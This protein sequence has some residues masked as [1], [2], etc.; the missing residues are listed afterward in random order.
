MN[1]NGG[2]SFCPEI[3]V[4]Q[5]TEVLSQDVLLTSES[6]SQ[7]SIPH[8]TSSIREVCTVYMYCSVYVCVHLC[9]CG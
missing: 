1:M 3:F 5:V 6:S 8:I 7:S 9:V 4:V 2:I